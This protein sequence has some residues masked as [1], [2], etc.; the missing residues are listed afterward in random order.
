MSRNIHYM[1]TN[2]LN[3]S[4]GLVNGVIGILKQIDYNKDNCVIRVW[5][6]FENE[7]VGKETR[8]EANY[9][10]V[11]NHIP[12]H[13]VPINFMRRTIKV[14]KK[15]TSI[16]LRRMFPLRI[17]EALTIHKS[18]GSTYTE[19]A[20]HSPHTLR[21]RELYV[22]CS[23][24]TSLS[25]LYFVNFDHPLNKNKIN[26]P[27]ICRETVKHM[28]IERPLKF[29]LL[30]LQ[31]YNQYES[32]IFANIQSL[33]KYFNSIKADNCF[34]SSTFI[35]LVETWTISTDDY[36]IPDYKCVYRHDCSGTNRYAYGMMIYAKAHC[37]IGEYIFESN[38]HDRIL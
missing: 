27:D 33:H 23:R 10:Y 1:I 13:W 24:V 15:N 8:S 18:Q 28:E 20:V 5:L 37:V 29:D 32:F 34:L 31:D 12:L 14:G 16:I 38:F 26:R 36:N 6:Q 11:K 9:Y 17:A 25:G 35:F 21:N 22:A 19:I 4:D 3:V 2:N 30:F 7:F